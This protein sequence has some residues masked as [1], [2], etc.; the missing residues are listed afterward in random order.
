MLVRLAIADLACA[1]R[2][3]SR[4]LADPVPISEHEASAVECELVL[5]AH[6]HQILLHV[7]A[8][9][10]EGRA[11]PELDAFSLSDREEPGTV[12]LSEDLPAC[13]DD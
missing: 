7:L 4:F 13:V 9:H 6:D 2:R 3:K 11:S 12:V 8:D 1:I 10:E 5:I